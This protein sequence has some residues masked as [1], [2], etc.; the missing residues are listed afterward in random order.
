LFLFCLSFQD[1][2][3]TDLTMM[4]L[5]QKDAGGERI[6]QAHMLRCDPPEEVKAVYLKLT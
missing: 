3:Q 1:S 5:F 4:I 6:L 2:H